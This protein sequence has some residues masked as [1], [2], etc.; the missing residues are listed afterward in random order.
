MSYKQDDVRR[1]FRGS[2]I[3][4]LDPLTYHDRTGLAVSLWDAECPDEPFHYWRAHVFVGR[5]FV[6][7][8]VKLCDEGGRAFY[9]AWGLDFKSTRPDQVV[10]HLAAHAPK[11][12]TDANE[13]L[14]AEP[15]DPCNLEAGDLVATR[16]HAL[17]RVERWITSEGKYLLKLEGHERFYPPE[18]VRP[19]TREERSKENV[20]A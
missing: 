20:P 14:H 10:Y 6:G 12:M 4:I 11:F 8:L 1:Q 3:T 18:F 19:L 15:G 17:S 13:R 2:G 9:S 5:E 16:F 7:T